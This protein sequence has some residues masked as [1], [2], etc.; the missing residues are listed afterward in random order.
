MTFIKEYN[1]FT[2]DAHTL[3]DEKEMIK[4]PSGNLKARNMQLHA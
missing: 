3:W 2:Q 1:G 4:T